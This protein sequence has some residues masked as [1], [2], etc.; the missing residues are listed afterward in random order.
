MIGFQQESTRLNSSRRRLGTIHWVSLSAF[1]VFLFSFPFPVQAKENFKVGV[2]PFNPL[3]FQDS[4]G[5]VRGIFADLINEIAEKKGWTLTYV[6]GSWNDELGQ[7]K[8]GTLDL[9]TSVMY[10]PER[11][12]YLDYSHEAAFTVW[13]D[14][15]VRPGTGI[16]N[17]L[18]LKGKKVAVMRGDL[19]GQNFIK[20]AREFQVDCDVIEVSSHLDVFTLV[21]TKQADAGV[22]PNIF[23]TI[24][25]PSFNLVPS[26]IIFNPNPLYFCTPAGE[27]VQLLA[28]IDE[29]L[30]IWKQDK[31]SFYYKTLNK[32][33]SSQEID[34]FILP[35]WIFY[36]IGGCLV[37]IVALFIWSRTLKSRVRQRTE[38][39]SESEQKYR[40]L[41]AYQNDAVFLHKKLSSGFAN[42]SEVNEFAVKHY[43]YS[44]EEFLNLSAEE[45]STEEGMD[46]F[47]KS[48]DLARLNE[49]GHH[50]FETEHRKKN[51]ERFPVEISSTHIDLPGGKYILSVARDISAR[52]QTEAA[53]RSKEEKFRTLFE[54]VTDYALVLKYIDHKLIIVDLNESACRW[55]GYTRQELIGKPLTFLDVQEIDPAVAEENLKTLNNG[56]TVK[57]EVNHR[58]KDGSIFPVE[59]AAN[60]ISI[61]GE[62]FLFSVERDLTQRNE[63]QNQHRELE[64]QLRQKFKMEA[65]GLMAGG[66]AHNFNNNLA[67]ILGNLELAQLKLGKDSKAGG[68]LDHAYIAACRATELVK[69]ILAYSRQSK[70]AMMVVKLAQII[71]ETLKLIRSTLPA[72]VDLQCRI[73]LESG[74]LSILADAIRIQEALMNLCTNAVHAMDERGVLIIS[75]ETVD[76]HPD[77]LLECGNC[78]PGPYARLGI[79]DSGCGMSEETIAKI[80]DPF[81]TTKAVDQGTGMGL[82]TVRGIV[83]QHWGLI[84]VASSLGHGTRFDLFF[85]LTHQPGPEEVLRQ[86]VLVEGSERILLVDD[87]DL[88][89]QTVAS[90]LESV[91]YQVVTENNGHAALNR[92]KDFPGEYDLVITDQT[93]PQMAGNELAMELRRIKP[94][95]PIIL[96][97]GFSSKI[98]G[99]EAAEIGVSS[100]LYKPLEMEKFLLEVRK[101]LDKSRILPN[102]R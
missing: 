45:I 50:V 101:V 16:E 10:T 40:T 42:F 38:A 57:I 54:H 70:S 65:V 49:T 92:F 80:F 73:P 87:E 37:I 78:Q 75:L 1:F 55:H 68:H 82:S 69:Q 88:L 66:I 98:S 18:S 95:L 84:K 100:L 74:E 20:L 14:V 97:T 77:D 83:D 94:D 89:L 26:P 53:L 4:D 28:A 25:A 85:P 44:R 71:D 58:R 24:N 33:L 8:A 31:N 30:K 35:V 64:R 60:L 23:G 41:L 11:D 102:L 2:F 67:I 46:L 79:Q 7:A 12:K 56:E 39:L 32:W 36:S 86:K 47:L 61:E 21:K 91:G 96:C 81:F 19:S 29:S 27:N 76:L 6:A 99:S 22:A 90:I 59:V 3:I 72:T 93:M 51:G 9:I 17:I 63:A 5:T 48:G 34:K 62:Q 43:G 52:K 13:G 15:Y